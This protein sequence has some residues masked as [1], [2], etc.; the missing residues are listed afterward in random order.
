MCLIINAQKI[1]TVAH[2]YLCENLYFTTECQQS[3]VQWYNSANYN[4]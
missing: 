3:T 4:F 1:E 2:A